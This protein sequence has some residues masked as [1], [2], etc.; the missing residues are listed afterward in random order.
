M[1]RRDNPSN[2]PV[3]PDE[4]RPNGNTGLSGTNHQ[5]SPNNAGGQAGGNTG[6]GQAQGNRPRTGGGGFQTS[7]PPEKLDGQEGNQENK[8]A[9][10][11]PV[12]VSDVHL[13]NCSTIRLIE[14]YAL[15]LF[16]HDP[17][18]TLPNHRHFTP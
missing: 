1:I 15:T 13:L 4:N 6:Q 16:C 7:N 2:A 17:S 9:K 14:N 3:G 18:W 8:P 12:S 11:S 10:V 5:P